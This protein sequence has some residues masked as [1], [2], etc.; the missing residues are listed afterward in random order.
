MLSK[1]TQIIF[2]VCFALYAMFG[3][4]YT[5]FIAGIAAAVLAIILIASN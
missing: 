5:L 3:V 4:A 2:Y 1:I